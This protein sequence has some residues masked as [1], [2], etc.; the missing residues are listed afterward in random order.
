MHLNGKIYARFLVL[1]HVILQLG[2]SKL[3]EGD[4]DQGDEDVDEEEGEHNEEDNVEYG[5]L[6]SVPWNRTL[7]LIRG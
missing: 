3:I 4:N 5:V 2:L 1:V 6:S 7:V